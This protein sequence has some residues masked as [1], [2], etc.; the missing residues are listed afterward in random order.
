MP[1]LNDAKSYGALTKFFH[2]VI[3]GLFAFQYAAGYTMTSLGSQDSALGFTQGNYYNWH[4]SIGLIALGFAFFRLL[5]RHYN[6][7]PKW[8]PNLTKSEKRMMHYYENA[9]YLAMFL[10]PV[11]GF[12]YVMAGGYG[13]HFLEITHLPNPIG[14]LS[15]LATIAKWTH[16]LSSFAILIALAAHMSVV[17]R[18]QLVLKNGLVWRMLPARARSPVPTPLPAGDKAQ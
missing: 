8:A 18:H 15:Q 6:R 2:W 13:V 17:L 10:M 9:L 4:K 16:I 14:K 5:N 7:L 3:V 11:S 1:I 12:V